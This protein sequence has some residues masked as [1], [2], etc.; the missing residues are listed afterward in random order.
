MKK[1]VI[2]DTH[3]GHKN[4][5]DYCA[6]PF[7][8]VKNMDEGMIFAWNKVVSPDDIVYHLGDFALCDKGKIRQILSQ[9]N[10]HK[11]LILGNHDHASKEWYL[12]NGFEKV[13]DKPV[14]LQDMRLV[15][16]HKPIADD[17]LDG[18][19]IVN[20]HGHTH[21]KPAD[22]AEFDSD[23]HLNASVEVIGYRPVELGRSLR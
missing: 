6:R 21:D 1:F 19:G 10:G 9:L 20:I 12:R 5:I 17:E 23:F 4:I 8:S 7:T 22:P 18:T 15:L 14:F 11:Y 2:S 3:F 16:S 13:W